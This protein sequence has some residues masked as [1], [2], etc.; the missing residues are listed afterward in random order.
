MKF[1]LLSLSVLL[2]FGD[3]KVMVTLRGL[4]LIY[5]TEFHTLIE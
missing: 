2:A 3:L 1:C 5:V 4:A